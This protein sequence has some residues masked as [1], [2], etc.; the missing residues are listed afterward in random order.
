ME[1][2]SKK[3]STSL[4]NVDLPEFV[5]NAAN[6]LLDE[7]SRA[8]G[9]TITDIWQIVFGNRLSYAAA[10]Q[11]L[12]YSQA[13]E[14][15][16]KELECKTDA[17][18]EEKRTEPSLQIVGQALDDSQYCI[19]SEELRSLFSSLIANSMNAD[20]ATLVHPS[21]SKIIQQMS[22]VDA[23]MIV[24]F[25]KWHSTGG[26][27]IVDFTKPTKSGEYTILAECV[28]AYAPENCTYAMAKRSI[29]SLQRL[30]LVHIP[31]GLY[32]SDLG[33]YAVFKQSEVY[34][35]LLRKSRIL[36]FNLEMK[37]HVAKLTPLGE[38]FVNV[39]L[40]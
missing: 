39:C 16:R 18:P 4:I 17:I 13:L 21:F 15:Y 32:L 29:F 2:P 22:P 35:D 19:E 37:K 12:K 27:P 26:I 40:G 14:D 36:G 10:K 20:Y 1:N 31:S 11:K 7:P 38:D 9:Q 24:L 33:R 34:E 25:Q 5:D 28:P 3:S 6:N 30:G 8:I 23:R